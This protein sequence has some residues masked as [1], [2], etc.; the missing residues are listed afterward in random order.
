[1]P[2]LTKAQVKKGFEPW[3]E[4]L[5]INLFYQRVVRESD[6]KVSS[7]KGV[8]VKPLRL[9]AITKTKPMVPQSDMLETGWQLLGDPTH[10]TSKQSKGSKEVSGSRL[11]EA[12]LTSSPSQLTSAAESRWLLARRWKL[13]SRCKYRTRTVTWYVTRNQISSTMS[14]PAS[15][16]SECGVKG[17][18]TTGVFSW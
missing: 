13:H 4:K 15:S 11:I 17:G 9:A 6:L 18:V 16:D 7:K 12:P 14:R 2:F 3:Q 8:S 5:H 10:K 1:M